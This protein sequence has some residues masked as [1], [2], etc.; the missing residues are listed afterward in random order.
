MRVFRGII[1]YLLQGLLLFH[2][3][4]SDGKTGNGKKEKRKK[5]EQIFKV[6]GSLRKKPGNV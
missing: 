6:L 4:S 1:T 5:T 2:G 3:M